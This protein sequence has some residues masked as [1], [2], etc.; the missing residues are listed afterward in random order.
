[1][2]NNHTHPR[3]DQAFRKGI[4]RPSRLLALSARL[5]ISKTQFEQWRLRTAE[6]DSRE[7]DKMRNQFAVLAGLLVV[8][9]MPMSVTA[10]DWGNLSGQIIYDGDPPTPPAVKITKDKECCGKHNVVDE[11][12]LVNA[13]NHGV[14]NVIIF[15]VP[16]RDAQVP[17]H[18][19]YQESANAE[20]LLDNDKCRFE[21]H[22]VLLRTG[23]KLKIGNSDPI[24]HNAKIDT[25]N[26]PPIN[27][28][29]PQGDF[30]TFECTNEERLPARVSC[31]IHPW[32]KAWVVIRSNPYMAVTDEEGKFEIKNLPVGT[33][34]FMF[35][36]EKAGYVAEVTMDGA[37]TKWRRGTV[38]LKIEPGDNDM[39]V[40]K[41][42]PSLFDK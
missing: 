21:P 40:I 18:E 25:F 11:S 19:S 26:N 1:V 5:Q 42:L 3:A 23:Q 34:K 33:H 31:S 6:L 37:K 39:G 36:Q 28:T 2:V 16:E 27:I 9:A 4:W 7:Q 24:G 8:T 10:E 12:L 35:W 38:E 41:V 17:V 22:V 14:R 29:I 20:V 32:M 15:L 13:E 30:R